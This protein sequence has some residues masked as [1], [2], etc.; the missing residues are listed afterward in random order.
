MTERTLAI[1]ERELAEAGQ[2][3][4]R[5]RVL[6]SSLITER[7]KIRLT[8]ASHPWLDKMVT[9]R[10]RHG[11]RGKII[12][13]KGVVVAYDPRRHHRLRS[14]MTYGL[15]A[16]DPIV[17]HANGNTGWNLFNWKGEVDDWELVA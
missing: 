15:S 4:E 7:D 10:Q 17:V 8:Q 3:R 11:Y 9:K 16:G 6:I 5:I 12:T 1:V 14:L 2:E 13:H